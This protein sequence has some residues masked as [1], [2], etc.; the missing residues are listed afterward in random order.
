MLA[1]YAAGVL[2]VA[3]FVQGLFEWSLPQSPRITQP[4]T[5]IAGMCGGWATGDAAVR[6]AAAY[7]ARRDPETH[8]VCVAFAMG[9]TLVSALVIIAIGH[10]YKHGS[11]PADPIGTHLSHPPTPPPGDPIGT[12]R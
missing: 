3:S 10:Y 8:A 11:P 12:D 5:A 2:V 9:H 7:A 1:M 6:T 4:V